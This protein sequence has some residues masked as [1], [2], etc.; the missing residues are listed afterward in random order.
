M[1]NET[2]ISKNHFPLYNKT[3]SFKCI[4]MLLH[5][6]CGTLEWA[7][8]QRPAKISPFIDVTCMIEV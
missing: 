5:L 8:I 1:V 7:V 4:L 6:A 2:M 3:F